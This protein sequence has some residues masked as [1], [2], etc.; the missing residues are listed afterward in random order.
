MQVNKQAE[1]GFGWYGCLTNDDWMPY[2]DK[3][4]VLFLNIKTLLY[5][6]VIKL[7]F[8]YLKDVIFTKK[9]WL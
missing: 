7:V 6:I 8:S 9:Q 4:I 2:S 5:L 3:I 1:N